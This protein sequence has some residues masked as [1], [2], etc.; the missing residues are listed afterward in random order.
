MTTAFHFLELIEVS[1]LFSGAMR[2]VTYD[3]WIV[4]M[5]QTRNRRWPR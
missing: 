1:R 5:D 3:L 2:Q 4:F